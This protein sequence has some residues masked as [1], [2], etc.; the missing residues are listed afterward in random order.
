MHRYVYCT[1]L[2]GAQLSMTYGTCQKSTPSMKVR[3]YNT[4]FIFYYNIVFRISEI[5]GLVLL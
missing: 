4:S 3:K 5:W 1:T 2:G